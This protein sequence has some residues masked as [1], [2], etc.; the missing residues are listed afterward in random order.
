M[1]KKVKEEDF[2][3]GDWV[4]KWNDI[5]EDKGKHGEFDHLWQGPYKI[6]A[7]HG[8]NTFMLQDQD[9]F[10]VGKGPINGR[11]LKHCLT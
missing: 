9:G 2:Q 11:F 6:S 8:N 3:F 5:I 1:I 4:L 10:L 7:C